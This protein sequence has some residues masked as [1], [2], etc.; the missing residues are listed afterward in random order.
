[1]PS[2]EGN[3]VQLLVGV[4]I[5]FT[6]RAAIQHHPPTPHP[7]A[8]NCDDRG[9]LGSLPRFAVTAA[10]SDGSVGGT[11]EVPP[12]GTVGSWDNITT[13]RKH[14]NQEN[15]KFWP[16]WLVLASPAVHCSNQNEKQK[17]NYGTS[18]D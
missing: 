2:G 6:T 7:E 3:R 18:E 12:L 13:R 16:I 9:I 1:M 10:G 17:G 5:M 11:D 14:H 4:I 8:I 15:A